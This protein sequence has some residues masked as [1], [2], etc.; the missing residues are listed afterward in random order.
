MGAYRRPRHRRRPTAVADES[1]AEQGQRRPHERGRND[2]QR[3]D[4]HEFYEQETLVVQ[5]E[6]ARETHP[7]GRRAV[8]R[9][10]KQGAADADTDLEPPIDGNEAPEPRHRARSQQGA[11]SKSAHERCQDGAGCRNGVPHD[12]RQQSRPCD[13]V[14][15]R[16]CA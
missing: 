15:E 14:H 13:F 12:E 5:A 8:E 9:D 11:Q 16:G 3:K 7:E 10:G 4:Q 6:D 1:L 2:E